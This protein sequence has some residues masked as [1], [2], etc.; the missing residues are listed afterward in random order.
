MLA[1]GSIDG[2]L[3]LWDVATRAPLSESLMGTGRAVLGVAYRPPDG[4]LLAVANGDGTVS[5]RD[6]RSGDRVGPYLRDHG[7]GARSVAF[8]SD[9]TVLASTGLDGRVI[10]WDVSP[11]SWEERACRAANR[12][13]TPAEWRKYLGQRDYRAVC[14]NLPAGDS[15][16]DDTQP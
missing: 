7:A 16:P 8:T 13:L 3:I 4:M 1:S 2:R 10:L 6:A 11:V 15:E 14:P 5:L 9:G 12:N